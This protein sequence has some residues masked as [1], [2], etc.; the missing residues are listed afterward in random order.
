MVVMPR[1]VMPRYLYTAGAIV[2]AF[3]LSSAGPVGDGCT[4]AE[5]YARQGMYRRTCWNAAEPYRWRSLDRWAALARSWWPSL[6]GGG[7]TTLLISFLERSETGGRRGA[8]TA[9]VGAHVQ[10][11]EAM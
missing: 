7:L 8:L 3:F 2:M 9:A 5:A 4:D 1:G 10:W 11:G 6:V